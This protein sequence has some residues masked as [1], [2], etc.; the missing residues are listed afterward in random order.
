MTQFAQLASKYTK[1]WDWR[2]LKHC[3]LRFKP[4]M[5]WIAT[6][7]S[8]KVLQTLSSNSTTI[9]SWKR[10][11]RITSLSARLIRITC[12]SHLL[13]NYSSYIAMVK[14]RNSIH[15]SIK[16]L[17][18]HMIWQTSI[19]LMSSSRCQPISHRWCRPFRTVST[20]MLMLVMK[21]VGW[22]RPIL[23]AASSHSLSQN[24]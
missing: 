6:S 21:R 8:I 12:P 10:S 22:Y 1:K 4:L 7:E 15:V 24:C 23:Q 17:E 16:G 3:R 11:T 2:L 9:L 13:T 19:E 5:D 14:E 18:S 20:L